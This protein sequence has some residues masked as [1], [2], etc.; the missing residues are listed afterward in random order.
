MPAPDAGSLAVA[1]GFLTRLPVGRRATTADAMLRAAPLYP[2]V[3]AAIGALV[4][5]VALGLA[6]LLPTLIAGALAVGLEVAVTGALH[7]DGLADSADGLAGRRPEDALAIMRDHAVGTYG[8]V[9]LALDLLVKAAALGA[10]AEAGAV[11]PVVAA[12]SLSRAAPLPLATAL[13]YARPGEGTG[14]L[15]GE[16]LGLGRA[17]AGVSIA[18]AAALAMV[19]LDALALL[20]AVAVV[21]ALVGILAR[22]RLRGVTGDVL[23]AATELSATVALVTAAGLWT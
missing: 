10:L 22:R 23:G 4:G 9:A 20:L 8:G 21:A 6:A 19:Q 17:A 7:V 2:I 3:G 16:R 5:A 1:T 13:P 11:A 15:L 12:L 18:A 14:R